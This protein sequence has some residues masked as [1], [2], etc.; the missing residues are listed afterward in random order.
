MK[1]FR[2]IPLCT[3][4]LFCLALVALSCSLPAADEHDAAAK[5][6]TDCV[7]N[8][9]DKVLV[10]HITSAHGHVVGKVK[11]GKCFYFDYIKDGNPS[12]PRILSA[13]ST[14][15]DLVAVFEFVPLDQNELPAPSCL[16]IHAG[17]KKSERKES[18]AEAKVEANNLPL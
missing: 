8:H 7:C 13:F 3:G 18:K 16:G 12:K 15:N 2:L 17:I 6:G 1:P 4:A 11:P 10:V 5:I 14:Q 9:T